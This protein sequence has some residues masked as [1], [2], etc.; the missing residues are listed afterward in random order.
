M[1]QATDKLILALETQLQS[2]C[3]QKKFFL[4]LHWDFSTG[5]TCSERGNYHHMFVNVLICECEAHILKLFFKCFRHR[6]FH[7]ILIR[8]DNWDF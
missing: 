5:M 6:E 2:C 7:N 8:V 1:P 4:H 3:G